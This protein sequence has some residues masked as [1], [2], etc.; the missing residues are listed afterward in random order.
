MEAKEKLFAFKL[1]AKESEPGKDEGKKWVA[2]EGVAT[3]GCS[4]VRFGNFRE[5]DGGVFC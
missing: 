3:A 4:E 2:R 1:V 5:G